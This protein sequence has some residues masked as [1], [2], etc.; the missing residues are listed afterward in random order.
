LLVL[1]VMSFFNL[2]KGHADGTRTVSFAIA[3]TS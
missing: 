3:P 2:L 1:G